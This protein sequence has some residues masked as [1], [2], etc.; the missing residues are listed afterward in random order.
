MKKHSD[1][2]ISASVGKDATRSPRRVF[3]REA[4]VVK[5][6]ALFHQH[7]YDALGIADLTKALDI[8]PPSLYA[9]FGSKAKLFDRC[10]EAYVEEA[11][12]PA[13]KILVDGRSLDTAIPAL[14]LEA[15][16]LYG[17]SALQRGCLVA[18]AMRADDAEARA[19]ASK[20]GNVASDFIQS[21]IARTHPEHA[22]ALA[23]YVVTT[24]RGLSA[25]ARV[26]LP[27]ARLVAVARLA[28]RSF[29]TLITI[30]V[31]GDAK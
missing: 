9:A 10:L 5:A 30:P 8:N 21:Y 22:R 19:L 20:Y 11:N 4:G 14:F 26:G 17:K 7:G 6:K 23:D 12:L 28:G 3:D 27:R 25:A 24:L 29:Q 16:K 31:D 18:E 15:A 2:A 1:A 13:E